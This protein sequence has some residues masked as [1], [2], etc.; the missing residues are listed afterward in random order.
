M[1]RKKTEYERV[2]DVWYKRLKDE[3]FVDI[4][5]SDGSINSG[6]PRGISGQDPELRELTEEYYNMATQFLNDHEFESE[7]DKVIWEYHTN[8]LSP[9][10]IAKVLNDAKVIKIGFVKI[11]RIIKNLE[12]IMKR[13]YLST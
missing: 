6:V 9:R 10:N 8:G 1:S 2:R 13:Q 3:G 7:L 4:E 11:W 12:A 5:H